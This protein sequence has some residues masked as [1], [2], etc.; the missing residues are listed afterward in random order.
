[1]ACDYVYT[2][3]FTGVLLLLASS[4]SPGL[5]YASFQEIH[6]SMISDS[7]KIYGYAIPLPSGNDTTFETFLNSRS[8]VLVNDLLREDIAVFW[9]EEP[10]SCQCS[11]IR[12]MR[13]VLDV[14]FN[15]GTF[16][17]PFVGDVYEDALMSSIVFDY[18]SDAEIDDWLTPLEGYLLLE[19][20]S[21]RSIELVEPRIAQFFG[22]STRYGWPV[23]LQI[24]DAG[25][26]LNFDFFLDN[27]IK[28]LLRSDSYNVFMWPYEPTPARMIEAMKN[29]IDKQSFNVI[30]RF[31][32]QGGGYI[33]SCYG[34]QIASSGF[35]Q[36]LSFFSLTYAYHPDKP[37]FPYSLTTSMSDTIQNFR[38]SLLKDLFISTSV[39][40]NS[41]HPLAFGVNRTVKDFFS[42]P[43]FIYLGRNSECVSVFD[44]IALETSSAPPVVQRIIGTPNWVVSSFGNGKLALF[45][46]HP[47]F[48]NNISLLFDQRIWPEDHY[49]GRRV[50]QNALFYVTGMSDRLST[51]GYGHLFS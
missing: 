29:L 27:D 3:L 45:A 31:V 43:W 37:C 28:T 48:V 15:K 22:T 4:S 49:Y 10:V 8:K 41:S 24:A 18:C 14:S 35:I 2:A 16:I 32:A 36:P 9:T 42:G 17:I 51:Q 39:I 12:D 26:F 34:A 13:N 11:P 6:S 38:W 50:I 30:R 20:L 47:E 7:S 23:Y 1:M 33:G 25:G 19:P 40:T 21:V 46:S 5:I 44:T